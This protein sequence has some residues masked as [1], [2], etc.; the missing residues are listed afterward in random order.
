MGDSRLMH[1]LVW[2]MLKCLLQVRSSDV[3]IGG[4]REDLQDIVKAT[5]FHGDGDMFPFVLGE[6]EMSAD[7][8]KR[9]SCD[10]HRE[11]SRSLQ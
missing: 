11:S 1:I 7:D 8:N 10:L 2:V 4:G 3:R 5:L 6:A 9:D